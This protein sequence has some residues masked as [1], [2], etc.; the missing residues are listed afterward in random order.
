M[1]PETMYKIFCFAAQGFAGGSETALLASGPVG[2]VIGFVIGLVVAFVG[3]KMAEQ[4]V[5]NA[6]IPTAVRKLIPMKVFYKQ[7][8]NK[9]GDLV[10]STYSHLA[11]EVDKK[12]DTIQQMIGNVSQSIG[13]QLTVEMEKAIL[14]I[15]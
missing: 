13:Q 3:T 14:L 10:K 12:T 9:K 6:N 11:S 1:K 8:E 4:Y 7:L 5:M 15:R 2:L